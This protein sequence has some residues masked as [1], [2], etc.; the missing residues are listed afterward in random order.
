MQRLRPWTAEESLSELT[1]NF[2]WDSTANMIAMLRV[3]L[4]EHGTIPTW[5]FG[6]CGGRPELASPISWAYTWPSIIGYALPPNHALI[7]LWLLMTAVGFLA[8]RAILLRWTRSGTAAVSGACVY[9]FSGYFA[10]RFNVGHVSFAFF[11]LVPVLVLLFEVAF[12][13]Y[14]RGES[15]LSTS[16]LAALVSYLFFSAGQPHGLL[17]FYPAVLLWAAFRLLSASRGGQWKKALGGVVAC[18]SA[19][20]LGVV[21]AAH[22]LWPILRWQMTS[23][24]AAAPDESNSLWSLLAS[25]VGFVSGTAESSFTPWRFYGQWEDFAFVGPLPW[26]LGLGAILAVALRHRKALRGSGDASPL[27]YALALVS[28]GLALAQGNAPTSIGGAFA[29]VP[30]LSGVRGF[31]R[32]QVLV[33]FGL[34]I[35]TSMGVAGLL[36]LRDR[37]RWRIAAAVLATATVVPVLVQTGVL[38]WHVSA[39]PNS[40]ILALYRSPGEVDPP[41]LIAS[42]P[43]RVWQAGHQSA[44]TRQGLWVANCY[45]NLELP[46]LAKQ[47]PRGRRLAISYP[48]PDRVR[49]LSKNEIALDYPAGRLVSLNLRTLEGFEFNVH[50]FRHRNRVIIRSAD[51]TEGVVS[52]RAV[53]PGPRTGIALSAVALVS[54]IGLCVHGFATR[55][56]K[57]DSPE[58]GAVRG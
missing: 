11:H 8:T 31:G 32:Y 52:I 20:A 30:L 33:V 34:S 48:P 40:E 7:S 41:E 1:L 18:L 43:W 16:L 47:I 9:A 36:S 17:Y 57:R 42:K 54:T 51:Q 50:P 13:R 53:Y 2:D 12:E 3:Y 55:S 28:I 38:V 15:M 4:Y 44:L 27:W 5:N 56:A 46:A 19:Q 49:Y 37:G 24:R 58:N 35:L 6:F 45:T 39:T 14:Q 25:T 22:K 21:L 29:S 26:M 23:P 10:A